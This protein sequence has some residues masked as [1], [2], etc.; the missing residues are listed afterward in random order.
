VNRALF[1]N[2]ADDW[3]TPR[4]VIRHWTRN[5]SSPLTRVRVTRSVA[6]FAVGKGSESTAILRTVLASR[7]GLERAERQS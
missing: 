7:S 1:S 4:H 6:S 5:S 2:V 3:K